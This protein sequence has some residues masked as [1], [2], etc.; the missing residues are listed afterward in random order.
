MQPNSSGK[1]QKCT[2]V[3]FA[4][5]PQLIRTALLPGLVEAR[6]SRQLCCMAEE[7]VFLERESS[8]EREDRSLD[9]S[10]VRAALSF[11]SFVSVSWPVVYG[12]AYQTRKSF[13]GAKMKVPFVIVDI[14]LLVITVGFLTFFAKAIADLLLHVFH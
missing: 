7:S 5:G 2:K 13:L 10:R 12:S 9:S 1:N 11:Q 4:V 3:L 14:F 6:F 8:R